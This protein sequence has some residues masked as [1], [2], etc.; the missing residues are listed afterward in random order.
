MKQTPLT[1]L[2]VLTIWSLAWTDDGS[3]VA[4]EMA[5]EA[6][7]FLGELQPEQRERAAFSFEDEERFNWHYIP[8]RRAGV[9]FR[10]MTPAQRKLA[11]SSSV[12]WAQ[13]S[14]CAPRSSS[15]AAGSPQSGHSP[16]QVP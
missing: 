5:T 14:H 13:P 9:P 4:Q 11:T 8:R 6:E 12:R 3:P 15:R 2:V 16:H 7:H 10:D 1:T